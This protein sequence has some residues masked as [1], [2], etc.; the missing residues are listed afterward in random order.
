MS[1]MSRP[2]I[3]MVASRRLLLVLSWPKRSIVHSLPFR[4]CSSRALAALASSVS[5]SPP[6]TANCG[7]GV[8]KSFN[9]MFSTLS[10]RVSPSTRQLLSAF[11]GR[12]PHIPRTR[13]WARGAAIV[14]A[15][16]SMAT[17][18]AN[19][20]CRLPGDEVLSGWDGQTSRRRSLAC[21]FAICNHT[22]YWHPHACGG[23][24]LPSQ[25]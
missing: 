7:S 19:F 13:F 14:S 4:S 1:P 17:V 9:G 18:A 8:S 22:K 11:V 5:A 25:P 10:Q 24:G 15:R 6:Q 12:L 2:P 20:I 23:S 21:R 3:V 16:A